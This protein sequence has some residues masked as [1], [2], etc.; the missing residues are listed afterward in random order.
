MLGLQKKQRELKK[1]TKLQETKRKDERS[2]FSVNIPKGCITETGWEKGD[3]LIIRPLL[4]AEGVFILTIAKEQ[5]DI[6]K[7]IEEI[8]KNAAGPMKP[9]RE[10]LLEHQFIGFPED[11]KQKHLKEQ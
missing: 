11:I 2:V 8:I 10:Y 4:M 1:M 6:D 5:D 3:K 7:R 9:T